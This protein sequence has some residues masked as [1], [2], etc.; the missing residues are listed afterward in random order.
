M[1]ND[2]LM[3]MKKKIR[4]IIKMRKRMEVEVDDDHDRKVEVNVF[5]EY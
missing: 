2:L 4:K 5:E 1:E 3:K